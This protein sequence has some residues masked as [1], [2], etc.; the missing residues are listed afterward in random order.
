MPLVQDAVRQHL[1]DAAIEPC[2]KFGAV[3]NGL[4]LEAETVFA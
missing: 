1:P 2:D 4:A 3:G